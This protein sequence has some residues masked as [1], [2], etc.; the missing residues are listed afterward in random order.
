MGYFGIGSAV[1]GPQPDQPITTHISPIKVIDT[2]KPINN[3][4]AMPP[5]SP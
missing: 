5:P 4:N 3:A 2:G 1:H